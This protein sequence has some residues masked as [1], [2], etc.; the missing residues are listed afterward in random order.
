MKKIDTYIIEKLHINKDTKII[1]VDP[2]KII[3]NYFE[4]KYKK[5]VSKYQ[6]K[7]KIDDDKTSLTIYLDIKTFNP[8][9]LAKSIDEL[10]TKNG[11]TSFS[12][13]RPIRIGDEFVLSYTFYIKKES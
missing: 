5:Y 6:F 12:Y 1:K 4:E 11:I 8:K 7:E 2:V 13:N 10:L 3:K 9:N